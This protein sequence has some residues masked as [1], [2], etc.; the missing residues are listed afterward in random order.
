MA[1]DDS[2]RVLPVE[3]PTKFELVLNLV[4]AKT[5]RRASAD[6]YRQCKTE[7]NPADDR[8]V[9]TILREFERCGEAMRSLNG[10]GQVIWKASPQM[11]ER[12]ASL[13]KAQLL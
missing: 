8:Q 1:D 6:S 5:L 2:S 7:I 12:L 3:Q 11:L 10:R 9:A 4:N 13:E